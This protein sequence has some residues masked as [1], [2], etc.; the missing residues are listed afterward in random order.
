MRI[1]VKKMVDIFQFEFEFGKAPAGLPRPG[2]P[3]T[4]LCTTVC[5]VCSTECMMP[6][7]CASVILCQFRQT[8][9]TFICIYQ[10]NSHITYGRDIFCRNGVQ[11][12][13]PCPT[14]DH[15][16]WSYHKYDTPDILLLTVVLEFIEGYSFYRLRDIHVGSYK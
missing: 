15:C 16:R 3:R 5:C 2:R 13:S 1:L 10:Y 6:V 12:K 4:L 7:Y 11:Q 8:S 9:K 14:P